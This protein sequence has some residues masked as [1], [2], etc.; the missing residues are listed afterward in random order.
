MTN[1]AQQIEAAIADNEHTEATMI[2]A[3]ALNNTLGNA[4]LVVLQE[5]ADTHELNGH[6]E[7]NH[8]TLRD[9]IQKEV[10]TTLK[11]QG[12]M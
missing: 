3:R 5:I 4:Y 2:A 9:A 1:L 6:I 7:P 12:K 8:R 10:F 11:L